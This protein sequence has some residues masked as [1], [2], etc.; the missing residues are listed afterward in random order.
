[1]LLGRHPAGVGHREG[2]L[3]I[4]VNSQNRLCDRA[5]VLDIDEKAVATVL[6]EILRLPDPGRHQRDAG[7]HRLE[8][9]LRATLLPRRDDVDI[10]RVV[11]TSKVTTRAR[12]QVTVWN[13]EPVEGIQH[14][15]AGEGR[16]L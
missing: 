10:E 12:K 7:C 8:N 16:G 2:E 11:G 14:V 4:A 3:P 1:M 15:A 9:A 5:G 13:A 6:D